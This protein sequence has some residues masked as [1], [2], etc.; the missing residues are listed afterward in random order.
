MLAETEQALDST[1]PPLNQFPVLRDDY[2]P[3]GS[4]IVLT[5]FQRP[6][7]D[8][9]HKTPSI[10]YQ[11]VTQKLPSGLETPARSADSNLST[12]RQSAG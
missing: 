10:T 2:V 3:E 1:A 6:W 5:Q 11:G 7:L 12:K 8:R 4:L 9:L